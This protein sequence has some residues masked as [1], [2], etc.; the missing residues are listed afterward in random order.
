MNPRGKAVLFRLGLAEEEGLVR[1]GR[2]SLGGRSGPVTT[3]KAGESG[4]HAGG[5]GSH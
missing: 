5:T 1:A 4:T 3:E 2:H